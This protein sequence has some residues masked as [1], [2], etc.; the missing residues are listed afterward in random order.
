MRC[1]AILRVAESILAPLCSVPM[2]VSC[3]LKELL[4][5]LLIGLLKSVR[6]NVIASP[7]S[8]SFSVRTSTS[9]SGFF[10]FPT[11]LKGFVLCLLRGLGLG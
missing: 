3:I 8:V 2:D 9:Q 7:I 5:G 4:F 11:F 10:L 6:E 1:L